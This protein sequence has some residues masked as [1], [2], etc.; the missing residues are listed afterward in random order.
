M[1]DTPR[2][3]SWTCCI[4][5]SIFIG[6][7]A[8]T[9]V[10]AC[11]RACGRLRETRGCLFVSNLRGTLVRPST[12]PPACTHGRTDV[13]THARLHACMYVS[14]HARTQ[15]ARTCTCDLAAFRSH[16]W[17]GVPAPHARTSAHAGMPCTPEPR[18]SLGSRCRHDQ[19]HAGRRWH[20]C[21][22]TSR[23]KVLLMWNA[24]QGRALTY[25]CRKRSAPSVPAG[26]RSSQSSY[27]PSLFRSNLFHNLHA[28]YMRWP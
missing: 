27:I 12:H 8:Y 24:R 3:S 21:V 2:T 4:C 28:W 11:I 14:T 26:T 5:V 9:R 18:G 17:P 13:R 10:C 6:A 23:S 15:A 7:G 1:I 25:A 16:A 19:P 22:S 20:R